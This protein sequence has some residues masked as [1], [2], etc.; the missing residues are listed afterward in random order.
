MLFSPLNPLELLSTFG[1]NCVWESLNSD[2][3]MIDFASSINESL[4]N[5]DKIQILNKFIKNKI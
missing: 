3:E 1:G 2:V 4:T 5:N